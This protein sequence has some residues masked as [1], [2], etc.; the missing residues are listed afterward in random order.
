MTRT[1]VPLLAIVLL[2]IALLA[3]APRPA[4][5]GWPYDP[6]VNVPLC[7]ALA[8]QRNPCIVLDGAGGAIVAWMD[9]RGSGWDIYAQ[10]VD[11]YGYL[12]AEPEIAVLR[13]VPNDQGGR[14]SLAWDASYL[15]AGPTSSVVDQYFI[16]RQLPLAL[17]LDRLAAGTR[18][19]DDDGK[20]E[21][22][23][24]RLLR[25]VTAD[26]PSYYWEYVTTEAAYGMP[27]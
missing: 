16:W 11:R 9:S 23:L 5:G 6:T 25:T 18:H 8:S 7:T 2:A 24:G 22:P 13:D 14:V 19:F 3:T 4:L 26:G 17:A 27:G 10:R 15:D 12:G 20:S 1:S 21:A